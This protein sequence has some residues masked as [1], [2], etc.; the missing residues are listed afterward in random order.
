MNVYA[1]LSHLHSVN[2]WLVLLFV[3]WAIVAAV[4]RRGS[5]NV[6]D[7]VGARAVLPK[8]ALPA[9]ITTHIQLLL[10]LILYFA[11]LAGLPSVGSP[12]VIMDKEAWADPILRFYSVTHFSWMLA[13]VVVITVG[14]VVAK[15]RRT[16]A[17]ANWWILVSY[18]LAL[19]LMLVASPWPWRDLGGGWY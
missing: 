14:Y 5:L 18:A 11:A 13:A 10:G 6:A 7:T 9:F 12:Y 8:G 19:V 16:T 1:L 4:T 15:R 17:Q 3:V 2:R